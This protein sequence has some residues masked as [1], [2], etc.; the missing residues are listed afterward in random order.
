MRW[1]L[2]PQPE[3]HKVKHLAE[4]LNADEVISCYL[5]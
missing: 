4:A 2:K 3:P 5:L 1:T